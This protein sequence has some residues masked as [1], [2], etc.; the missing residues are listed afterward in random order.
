MPDEQNRDRL[1]LERTSLANERTFLAYIRTAL[2]LLICAA[3][4]LHI[5]PDYAGIFAAVAGLVTAGCTV[6]GF[7]IFRFFS[8][9]RS[10]SE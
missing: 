1:A 4:L 6:L 7:G 5:G 3:A 9:R 2:A 10:L 8:V